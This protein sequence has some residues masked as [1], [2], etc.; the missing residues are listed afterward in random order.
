MHLPF[1]SC[2]EMRCAKY[3]EYAIRVFG[4]RVGKTIPTGT[5]SRNPD[6][7]QANARRCVQESDNFPLATNQLPIGFPEYKVVSSSLAAEASNNVRICLTLPKRSLS[8]KQQSTVGRCFGHRWDSPKTGADSMLQ[9]DM[10]TYVSLLHPKGLEFVKEEYTFPI[11]PPPQRRS[12]GI[13]IIIIPCLN[14]WNEKYEGNQME[15]SKHHP[16]QQANET[17]WAQFP[18]VLLSFEHASPVAPE[19]AVAVYGFLQEQGRKPMAIEVFID[20]F[21]G[22]LRPTFDWQLIVY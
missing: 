19:S 15:T 6:N 11:F 18:Q 13:I 12:S 4:N 14:I 20:V 16:S 10:Y 3:T 9:H 8:I 7:F 1:E 17:S 21:V 5:V 22:H 2:R